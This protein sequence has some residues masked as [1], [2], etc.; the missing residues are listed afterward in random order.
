[1][2]DYG[3]R[4]RQEPIRLR[5]PHALPAA[6]SRVRREPLAG[7]PDGGPSRNWRHLADDGGRRAGAALGRYL[8]PFFGRGPAAALALWT[9][10]GLAPF[11]RRTG[12][13]L[14]RGGTADR[15]FGRAESATGG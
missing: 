10:D 14:L 4:S 9:R 2:F 8:Q 11:L 7:R 12:E 13:I 6:V 15:R 3:R 1:P 5:E